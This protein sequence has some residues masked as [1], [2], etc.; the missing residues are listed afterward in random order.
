MLVALI[1]ARACETL[2]AALGADPDAAFTAG[3]M[4]MLEA[5]FER[6]LA[7]LVETLPLAAEIKAAVTERR[8]TLGA[9][10]TDVLA[11]EQ[12]E[13]APAGRFDVGLV[14]RA[15]FEALDWA[16]EAIGALR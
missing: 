11:R 12:K 9:V 14:N 3:L 5:L 8:G 15:W 7:E 16:A 6:P 13:V 10:L 4:S 2:A 1:R